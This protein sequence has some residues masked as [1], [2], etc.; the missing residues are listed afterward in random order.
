M[1]Q[2][3]IL[4]FFSPN[5]LKKSIL[6][7]QNT[8]RQL[9]DQFSSWPRFAYPAVELEVYWCPESIYTSSGILGK[10]LALC[11]GSGP[12][13]I[14]AG[15]NEGSPGPG[16]LQE[17]HMHTCRLTSAPQLAFIL[18]P[19]ISKCSDHWPAL[20]LEMGQQFIYSVFSL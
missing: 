14:L 8:H 10:P 4:V 7:S 18:N 13:G 12:G 9:G 20:Y 16:F 6:S 15:M 2:N 1:L 11:L 17:G 5:R 19:L 3:I